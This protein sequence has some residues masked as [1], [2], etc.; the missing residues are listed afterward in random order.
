MGLPSVGVVK[1]I[2]SGQSRVAKVTAAEGRGDKPP[3]NQR[4]KKAKSQEYESFV[5]RK[6]IVGGMGVKK[7]HID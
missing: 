3:G 6:Y 5:L 4:A 7:L 2:G 1:G